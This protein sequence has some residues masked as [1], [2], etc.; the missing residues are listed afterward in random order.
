MMLSCS[1]VSVRSPASDKLTQVSSGIPEPVVSSQ[2]DELSFV[3]VSTKRLANA[4]VVWFNFDLA[5]E[6][7]IDIPKEGLT[8]EFE[9]KLLDQFAYAIPRD[10]GDPN[11]IAD[12]E[13]IFHADIYG[14][15]GMGRNGGSGRAAAVGEVQVKG[16]G[17][18]SLVA[19]STSFDHSHG[20]ASFKESISEAIWGEITHQELPHGGNRVL[21]I[22]DS[23][24]FTTWEDG[25]KEPRALIVRQFPI[26]P[27]N[28]LTNEF[29]GPWQ[30]VEEA[31]INKMIKLLDNSLPYPEGF[32]PKGLSRGKI[33]SAGIM[34]MIDRF[35]QQYAAAMARK[36]F[37]AACSPSNIE[38]DG[39]FLDYGTM[40]ALPGFGKAKVLSIG[41]DFL[42]EIDEHVYPTFW[43]L[44][45]NIKQFGGLSDNDQK[46]LP[47]LAQIT[48]QVN[49]RFIFYKQTEVIRLAG[50]PDNIVK[51]LAK[52]VETKK[53]FE[54]IQLVI[55][56]GNHSEVNVDKSMPTKMGTYNLEEIFSILLSGHNDSPKSLAAKLPPKMSAARRLSLATAYLDYFKKA[57]SHAKGDGVERDSLISFMQRSIKQR[58]KLLPDLYRPKLQS[59]NIRLVD[60]YVVSKQRN[61]IWDTIDSKI[62]QNTITY[63]TRTPYQI[64]IKEQRLLFDSGRIAM[65]Y[66]AQKKSSFIHIDIPTHQSFVH[67]LGH[68]IPLD[69]FKDATLK[70]TLDGWNQIGEIKP[71]SLSQSIHFSIP[72][73]KETDRTEFVLRSADGS[74]Y[75]KNKNDNY[76]F[77]FPRIKKSLTDNCYQLIS[78]LME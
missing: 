4:K 2:M 61:L 59:E 12:D 55:E 37:H 76:L 5:H 41:N 50:F 13:K 77:I 25:G 74:K 47:T 35:A 15:Y 72:V 49:H 34:D 38:I 6:M 57:L 48:K 28:F 21:M 3:P 31:R 27:A 10:D 29:P 46:A 20:G 36:L 17:I 45:N 19:P 53:L 23:G 52:K 9:E 26:R 73:D 63:K 30:K 32:D 33:L 1:K 24:D 18:T 75:W 56:E 71:E 7:G 44:I 16:I 22:I 68:K 54:Q 60:E 43:E 8:P 78:S 40:T 70:Y 42:T 14:G 58:N 66:D 39:R 69:E 11:F 64:V 67:F 51:T 62:V 65:I